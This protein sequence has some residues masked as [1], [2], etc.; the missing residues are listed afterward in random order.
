V[1]IRI[2]KPISGIVQRISLASLKPGITYDVEASMAGYLVGVGA[3]DFVPSSSP[4]VVIPLDRFED[5]NKAL[6]GVSVTQIAEAADKPRRK[7]VRKP[8]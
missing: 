8:R 1:R 5:F 4:A 7:R 6:G 2:C 3:A